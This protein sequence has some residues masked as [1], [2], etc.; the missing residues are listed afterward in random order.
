MNELISCNIGSK[1]L[2]ITGLRHSYKEVMGGL[3]A[4]V[5]AVAQVEFILGL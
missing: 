1:M 4:H 2:L 5:A 3:M